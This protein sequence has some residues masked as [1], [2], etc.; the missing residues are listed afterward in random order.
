MSWQTKAVD[1]N[2]DHQY[3]SPDSLGRVQYIEGGNDRCHSD[4]CRHHRNQDSDRDLQSV[5]AAIP[6]L[7]DVRRRI[8]GRG[9]RS[10][11]RGN[12]CWSVW[13]G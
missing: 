8:I 4:D 10:A 7:T 12:R 9:E 2:D 11:F 1:G 5:V 13:L 3:A 6:L